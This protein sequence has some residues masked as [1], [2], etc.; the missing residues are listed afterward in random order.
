MHPDFVLLVTCLPW[1]LL[2]EERV[3]CVLQGSAE[4]EVDT[5][6][7]GST[8]LPAAVTRSFAITSLIKLDLSDSKHV[9]DLD[10]ACFASLCPGVKELRLERCPHRYK[11]KSLKCYKSLTKIV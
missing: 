8:V 3:G 5:K 4:L 10:V 9:S 7:G 2:H 11:T 6:N 1:L